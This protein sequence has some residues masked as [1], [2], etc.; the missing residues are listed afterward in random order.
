MSKNFR[1]RVARGFAWNHLYKVTEY[2]LMN[3]YNV[4]VIR[5]FGPELV[6]PYALYLSVATTLSLVGAFAV[7]GTLLR[8][9]SHAFADKREGDDPILSHPAAF[10]QRLLSLRLVVISVISLLVLGGLSL[11]GG[12]AA[13]SDVTTL[14]RL[15]PYLIAYLFAQAIAAFATHAMLGLLHVRALFWGSLLSRAALLLLGI[16]ALAGDSLTIEF[17]V[18]AHLLT[19]IINAAILI[20]ALR[21]QVHIYIGRSAWFRNVLQYSRQ[22]VSRKGIAIVG[23]SS[24]LMYGVTTWGT[25]LLSA[26][27][28][29]QPDI[30]MISAIHGER[31]IEVGFYQAAAMFLLFAEYVML[32]GLGGTL[33]AAFSSLSRDDKAEHS[34]RSYPRLNSA[35][36]QVMAF[37]TVVTAPLFA[38]LLLFAREAV[39]TIFGHEFLPIVPIV[40]IGLIILIACNTVIG[41]GVHLTALVAAG[42][43]VT[44]FRIRLAY[45][46]INLLANYFLILHYGALGA[47]IGTQVSNCA[48]CLTESVIANR[49]LGIAQRSQLTLKLISCSFFSAAIPWFV[50]SQLGTHP[51]INLG[52]GAA[53]TVAIY[54]A[55]AYLLKIAEVQEIA[56]RI[57][58]ALIPSVRVVGKEA[59]P[60]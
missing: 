12:D 1:D 15:S 32:F 30:L 5:H 21:K 3:L 25:D 33:V 60:S 45:G 20:Y 17:A 28:S 41:G 8:F 36:Q 44:V 47:V 52:C 29:R 24:V 6:G 11:W 58:H 51:Y 39:T 49:R 46:A 7:D 9:T 26:I 4:L 23:G 53:V 31:S 34:D 35:R 13:S 10:L 2:G 50:F 48:A 59:L 22:F 38:F 14:Y 56:G 54:L 16:W 42:K 57:R 40:E 27:L 43:Q 55:T 18:Q 19:T 37:Q